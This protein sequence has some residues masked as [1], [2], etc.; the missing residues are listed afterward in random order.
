M[1]L[2]GE[3]VLRSASPVAIRESLRIIPELLPAIRHV[4]IIGGG[5]EH[6]RRYLDSTRQ[7]LG[8]LELP[9]KVDYIIG[10][11]R[12]ELLD[13]VRRLPQPGAV[14]FLTYEGDAH[15]NVHKDAEIAAAVSVVS[16]VPVFGIYDSLLGS[17]IVGGMLTNA[18]SY[19]EHTAGIVLGSITGASDSVSMVTAKFDSRQLDR[20]RIDDSRLPPGSRILFRTDSLWQEYQVELIATAIV[21]AALSLLSATFA[22]VILQRRRVEQELRERQIEIAK[23]LDTVV[24]G[25]ISV[26]QLAGGIAHDFNNLLTIILGNNDLVLDAI[27]ESH[28]ARGFLK[29]VSL[30]G[31]RAAKLIQKLLAFSRIQ[32]LQTEVLD[33]GQVVNDT[34]ELLRR[35]LRENIAINVS[36]ENNLWHVNADRNQLENVVLN[37]AINARDAI[38]GSGR[39]TI[40]TSNVYLSKDSDR[41]DFAVTE[42]EYVHL[43][44][45]DTG[46]GMSPEI[47]ALVFEPFFTTKEIGKGSGLGL[48]MIYGYVKQTGGYV[49]VSSEVGLG[50]SISIYLPRAKSEM[51]ANEN[52]KQQ[53]AEATG[54]GECILVVEDDPDVRNLTVAILRNLG[55]LTVTAGDSSEALKILDRNHEDIS[56]LLTDVI[57]TGTINGIQ[58]V[59]E[60]RR[61]WPGFKAICVSGYDDNVLEN[62]PEVVLLRKPFARPQLALEVQK[63][64]AS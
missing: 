62:G 27:E 22:L 54:A 30:A 60:V 1:E 4:T 38:S 13:R 10:L 56:L 15:N 48:S 34:I 21:M 41:F 36:H 14:L 11:R 39:L 37:L 32:T 40:E 26:D 7:I 58:L 20:W 64:L 59:E 42:G 45:S 55:Y 2:R 33:P 63:A 61:R 52:K 28:P 24:E 50:T 51:T 12:E 17:G 31:D 5:T 35:T 43:L 18:E 46:H 23:I 44:V 6:D 8:E 25:V 47:S 9:L 49:V 53:G 3:T 57:L 16:N 19:A 29:E